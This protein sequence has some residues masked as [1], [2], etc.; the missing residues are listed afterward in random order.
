MAIKLNV[1]RDNAVRTVETMIDDAPDITPDQNN[2]SFPIRPQSIVIVYQSKDGSSWAIQEVSV[3]GPSVDKSGKINPHSRR[4]HTMT[5]IDVMGNGG[6]ARAIT[7]PWVVA[8]VK[9]YTDP[10]KLPRT[11]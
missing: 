11:T 4:R 7:P 3:T 1:V 5:Y 8:M 9:K 2:V 6:I 10:D